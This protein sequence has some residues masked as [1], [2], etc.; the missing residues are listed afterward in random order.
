MIMAKLAPHD[1]MRVE[2]IQE[3]YENATWDVESNAMDLGGLELVGGPKGDRILVWNWTMNKRP[4]ILDGALQVDWF[5]DPWE[6]NSHRRIGGINALWDMLESQFESSTAA[7]AEQA[8][9]LFLPHARQLCADLN[10]TLLKEEAKLERIRDRL[11]EEII[12][13]RERRAEQEKQLELEVE[14]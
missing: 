5:G 7:A 13:V 8:A 1:R 2:Q 10:A 3:E 14:Q 12:R 9:A 4:T 11:T 6:A